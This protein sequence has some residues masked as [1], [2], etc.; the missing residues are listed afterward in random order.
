M[1]GRLTPR[2]L[3]IAFSLCLATLS[4][5]MAQ[6]MVSV[7]G[8]TVNMRAQPTTNAEVLWELKRGYPLQVLKQRGRWLKVR[9][10]ENDSGWVARSLTG[11]TPHHVVRSQVANVRS[12]PSLRSRIVAKASY[13]ESL[14]TLARRDKWVRVQRENGQTGWIARS[15]L[16]GF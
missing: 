12:G 11:R 1:F 15:L 13:G 8:S 9:D 6:K 2:H 5:A 3:L 7:K 16:W 14:R 10:F 4:S